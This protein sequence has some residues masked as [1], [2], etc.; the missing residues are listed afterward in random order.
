MILDGLAGIDSASLEQLGLAV[1]GLS[2]LDPTGLGW[3]SL[4]SGWLAGLGSTETIWARL[5]SAKLGQAR[6]GLPS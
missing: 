1:L 3:N 4:K 2:D 6:M 5:E